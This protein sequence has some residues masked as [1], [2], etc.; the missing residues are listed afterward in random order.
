MKIISI[1]IA[2]YN[3][4]RYI[5]RC[6]NSIVQQKND[7]IELIIIDG[8]SVDNTTQI[9]ERY[10]EQIDCFISEKDSGIYDAWNKGLEYASGKWIQFIGADDILLPGSINAYLYFLETHN[11]DNIDFISA[12]SEYVNSRGKLLQYI[13]Q[14]YTWEKFRRYMC[15]SHGSTLH[16][17][18]M[19]RETGKYNTCFKICADYELLLRKKDKINTLFFNQFVIRMQTGGLSFSLNGQLETYRIKQFHHTIPEILNIYY[20]IRGIIGFIIKKIIWRTN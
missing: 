18:N 7:K 17:K 2:T 5:E 15:I 10:N 4:E 12:K 8:L 20:L 13:G 11:T 19:F 6:I 16:N 3:A 1:I 9:I 14:A